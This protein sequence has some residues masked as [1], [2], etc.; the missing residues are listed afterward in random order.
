[1]PLD[2]TPEMI[3]NLDYS[4]GHKIEYWCAVVDR[5]FE[6]PRSPVD[7]RP[8]SVTW[9]LAFGLRLGRIR[10]GA[11]PNRSDPR[12]DTG[13]SRT[14]LGLH[15]TGFQSFSRW[16]RSRPDSRRAC[17]QTSPEVRSAYR[18][19]RRGG[20]PRGQRYRT[21]PSSGVGLTEPLNAAAC[22]DR[23]E[24]REPGS[25]AVRHE[26]SPPTRSGG[27]PDASP[28]RETA[29]TGTETTRPS[30]T[31][32]ACDPTRKGRKLTRRGRDRPTDGRVTGERRQ[33]RAS[34]ASPRRRE[35]TDGTANPRRCKS[36]RAR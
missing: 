36:V 3:R 29:G 14:R 8:L 18:A 1:V 16:I 26:E 31:D 15:S 20:T 24:Q 23:I 9:S 21:G 30:S 6:E 10:F 27:R 13:G 2:T 12:T 33:P 7:T 5:R 22:V 32:E 4:G 28:G 25:R 11:E 19:R 34:V 17:D 35:G